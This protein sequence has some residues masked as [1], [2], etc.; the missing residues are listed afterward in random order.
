MTDFSIFDRTRFE[1]TNPIYSYCVLCDAYCEKEF[2]KT[3]PMLKWEKSYYFSYSRGL[4][5]ILVFLGGFGG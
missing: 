2:E 3:K 5:W 4:W 1:K